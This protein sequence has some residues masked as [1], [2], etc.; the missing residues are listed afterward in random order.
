[1]AYS[2]DLFDLIHAMTKSEKRYFKLFSSG[3]SGDKEY[4]NLFN[5]ISKQEYYDEEI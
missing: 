5:A 1:M 3:Q 4:I 2:N